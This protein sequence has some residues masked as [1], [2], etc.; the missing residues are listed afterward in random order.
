MTQ[1]SKLEAESLTLGKPEWRPV[2]E[3]V[4][5]LHGTS[6]HPPRAPL[7]YPWEEI[8]PG[9]NLAFGHWDLVHQILDVLPTETEHARHQILNDLTN[10]HDDGFL[11]GSIWFSRE[12]T[13]DQTRGFVDGVKWSQK[14]GHPP[15][16]PAAVDAWT[17]VTGSNELIESSLEPLVRQI[18][19]FENNRAAEPIGFFYTDI[20]LR[21]WESGVDE[22]IRFDDAPQ[23]K[24]ACIDATSHV[25]ELYDY[26]AR[27][28]KVMGNTGAEFAEKAAS[29]RNFIQNELFD[30]ET[31]WFYD[32]WAMQDPSQ[33][34]FALE[35]MFPLVTGASSPAQAERVIANL[36]DPERFF[37]PHPV[38]T[39][40][41]SEPKFELRM[42]RGPSWNSM[43]YWAARGC[44]RYGRP[45]AAR[46]L[47]EKSLDATALEFSRSGQLWE[48]Y[49]PFG[50]DPSTIARKPQTTRNQPFNDYL[51]HNPLLAMARLYD[52]TS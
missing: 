3:Y 40:A 5:K 14:A 6:T 37:A 25:Y 44:M 32:I 50:G 39:V 24:F 49:H 20:Q 30:N 7:P 26:A 34:R 18:R 27:W 43:T 13:Q 46:Q 45:D 16:W 51:G 47:I 21:S 1:F 48:F 2:L 41:I 17:Q 52:A 42:W 15:V 11:P 19:W 4:A 35:G 8:G 38:S 33:R 22:G 9:Y 23:G 10:Q 12:G 28:H 31:G 29:L 36:L